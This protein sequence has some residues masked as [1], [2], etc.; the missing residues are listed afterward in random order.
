V[1]FF[2]GFSFTIFH[3]VDRVWRM[4][5]ALENLTKQVAEQATEIK[6]LRGENALL[7][8]KLQALLH[9]LFG[10]K[11]EKLDPRQLQLL[12]E[13]LEVAEV[14]PEDDP[15]PATPPRGR[16]KRGDLLGTYLHN[17]HCIPQ[18]TPFL[19]RPRNPRSHITAIASSFMR[20]SYLLDCKL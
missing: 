15:P 9:R 5:S 14:E 4:E 20:Q 6:T 2:R 1:T 7:R 11:S 19:I 10:R 13:A 17:S 8:Q 18:H 16:V 3:C 12:L